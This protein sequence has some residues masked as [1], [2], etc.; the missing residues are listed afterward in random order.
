MSHR[1]SDS[2]RASS[3][4][5]SLSRIDAG[6]LGRESAGKNR[7]DS[8]TKTGVSGNTPRHHRRH[9]RAVLAAIPV[10]R[11]AALAVAAISATTLATITTAAA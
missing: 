10:A 2:T 4:P 1:R 11:A 9:R 3:D 8:S 5:D 7:P 6:S